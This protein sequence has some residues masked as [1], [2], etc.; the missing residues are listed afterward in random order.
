[1][2]KLLGL[3]GLN[4]AKDLPQEERPSSAHP[5]FQ[6]LADTNHHHEKQETP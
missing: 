3:A 5:G 6:S 4:L 1:M 2:R